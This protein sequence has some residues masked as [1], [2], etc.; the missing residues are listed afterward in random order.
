MRAF[1]SLLKYATMRAI[2]SSSRH[3]MKRSLSLLLLALALVTPGLGCRGG[4]SAAQEAL[5]SKVVLNWWAVFDDGRNYQQIIQDYQTLHPN[6]AVNFR[7]LRLD[8]YNNEL[9]R[10][11]AED[12]GPD[13]L[14]IHNTWIPEYQT[15]IQPMPKSTKLVFIE[16]RGGLKK[17]QIPTLR[18]VPTLSLRTLSETYVDVV[19]NDVVK[20]YQEN[21]RSP[22]ENRIWGLPTSVDSLALYYNKDLLNNAGIAEPPKT[23][24]D[25]QNNVKA[26]TSLDANGN[27]VQSGAAIGTATNVE[28]ASDLL[29]VIMMQNGTQMT[30]PNGNATF[31][32][33]P[34][35]GKVPESIGAL[36]FYTDFANPIKEV[37]TWNEKQPSS[38]EAFANGTTAFFFGYSYHAPLLSA[39]NPKLN[40]AVTK[41]P[42][43]SGG[44]VVNFANYWV[45]TVAKSSSHANEAWDFIQFMS[46]KDHVTSYLTAAKRPTALRELINS[47]LEDPLLNAFASQTLT[48]KSWYKGRNIEAA[49]AAMAEL[50]KSA[51]SGVVFEDALRLAQNKV[52][53]TL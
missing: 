45:Q 24:R 47:Q 51:L 8:E 28:R 12:R 52:N 16:T 43:I 40:Y 21:S 27:I 2:I 37:Y 32:N 30:S 39:R 25:F 22:V 34:V 49:E 1:F 31:A 20:P 17:E 11:F 13:I 7:R 36:Q 53:Q 14:S 35:G 10:A 6:V 46:S 18:E 19:T 33:P 42:Q 5:L 50:I 4:S 38:F 44:Q 3:P 26:L 48:A 15:L 29:S 23:W 41:L 9:I